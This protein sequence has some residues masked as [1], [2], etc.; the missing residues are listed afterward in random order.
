MA[1]ELLAETKIIK[2]NHL[3]IKIMVGMMH[4]KMIKLI[5]MKQ[6]TIQM[7]KVQL[8]HLHLKGLL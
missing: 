4:I 3:Q 2:N 6:H 1:G 8:Q 7:L 5:V